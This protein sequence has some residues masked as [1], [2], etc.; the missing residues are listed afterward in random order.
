M[1]K[2]H[3]K[4]YLRFIYSGLLAEISN[5]WL[6]GCRIEIVQKF[7]RLGSFI[8]N[9][10]DLISLLFPKDEITSYDGENSDLNEFII[11]SHSINFHHFVQ[12]TINIQ[13]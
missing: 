13:R 7:I 3:S 1:R 2:D 6:D 9:R 10:T 11:K 12:L 8:F 4:Q 5:R